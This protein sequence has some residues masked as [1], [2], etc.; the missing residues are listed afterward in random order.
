MK[1]EQRP[2][3]EKHFLAFSLWYT[4]D[5]KSFRTPLPTDYLPSSLCSLITVCDKVSQ[6]SRLHTPPSHPPCL[7]PSLSFSPCSC[8]NHPWLF[9][10]TIAKPCRPHLENPSKVNGM[11]WGV[12]VTC[13]CKYGDPPGSTSASSPGSLPACDPGSLHASHTAQSLPPCPRISM[14]TV[15]SA[16]T[17]GEPSWCIHSLQT[18][19][20]KCWFSEFIPWP[21]IGRLLTL[22]LIYPLD[23]NFP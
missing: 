3:H 13:R 8:F 10:Q 19:S 7:P 21:K 9:L 18:V 6:D 20:S 11:E 15:P 22:S 14:H 16:V 4:Q 12:E 2:T 5:H 23:P 17:P 1:P